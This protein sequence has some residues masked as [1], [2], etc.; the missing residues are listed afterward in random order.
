RRVQIHGICTDEDG[1]RLD[2]LE[3]FIIDHA[4]KLIYVMPTFQ[5]PAGHVMPMHRRRQLLNLAN[6]YNIPVLEDAIYHEFRFE[7][8]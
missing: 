1:I 5:N 7:G 8:E 4:P 3:N 6:E 2:H